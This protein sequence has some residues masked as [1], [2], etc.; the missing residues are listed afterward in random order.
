MHM[1]VRYLF[2]TG[3]AHILDRDIEVEYLPG[4]RMIAINRDLIVRN[5]FHG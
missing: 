4:Q 2:L 1:S 3:F 5:L